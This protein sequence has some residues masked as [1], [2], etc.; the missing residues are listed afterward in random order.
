MS[1]HEEGSLGG[2]LQ[3]GGPE[4]GPILHFRA[5]RKKF[6]TNY[7]YGDMRPAAR[8]NNRN[9]KTHVQ[10]FAKGINLKKAS[11]QLKIGTWTARV[12]FFALACGTQSTLFP[13]SALV[14]Q[15]IDAHNQSLEAYGNSTDPMTYDQAAEYINKLI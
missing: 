5:T 1:A 12:S 13:V 10:V 8:G 3:L 6:S 11:L 2:N 15:G 4:A 14:P 9:D 7:N